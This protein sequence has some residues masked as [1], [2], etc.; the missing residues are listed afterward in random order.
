MLSIKVVILSIHLKSTFKII[1]LLFDQIV[2]KMVHTK[3]L[4]YI[5]KKI[6]HSLFIYHQAETL[7][8]I[9]YIIKQN[10]YNK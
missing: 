5:Y 1:T 2:Y 9:I 3:I 7:Y 10:Y 8:Y 4:S 6:P